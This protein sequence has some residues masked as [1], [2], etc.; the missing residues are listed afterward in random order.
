MQ[1][2]FP[3]GGSAEPRNLT[4]G[5]C[6][7]AGLLSLPSYAHGSIGRVIHPVTSRPRTPGRDIG[8]AAS[9]RLASETCCCSLMGRTNRLV[10][11]SL[12][13][14][15][16]WRQD[17]RCSS[18][19]LTLARSRTTPIT[20]TSRPPR[21]PSRPLSRCSQVRLRAAT[22]TVSWARTARN[23]RLGLAIHHSG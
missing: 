7:Y 9:T 14:V 15:L 11:L 16:H 12:R 22:R 8:S 5:L 18:S 21:T 13:P 19:R 6:A 17:D 20:E 2:P 1:S 10:A 23:P 4:F 3:P